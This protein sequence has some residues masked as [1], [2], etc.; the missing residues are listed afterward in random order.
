MTYGTLDNTLRSVSVIFQKIIKLYVFLDP[1]HSLGALK[2]T[3]IV[4]QIFPY[5][6]TL[7]K[8]STRALSCDSNNITKFE[9]HGII[10]SQRISILVR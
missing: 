1:I 5:Y 10:K 3:R 2:N 4:F 7:L 6:L 9:K 8:L